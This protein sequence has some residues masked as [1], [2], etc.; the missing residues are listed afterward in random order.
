MRD[1]SAMIRTD[2]D[3]FAVLWLR[4]VCEGTPLDPLL[5]DALDPAAFAERAAAVRSRL[6]VPLEGTV[7]ELVCEGERIAWRWTLRGPKGTVRGV[8]F[9]EI[10]GGRAVAHWTLAI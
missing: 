5:G 7:D 10:A 6:G 3:A 2:R 4:S 8:N 9:Q 1:R